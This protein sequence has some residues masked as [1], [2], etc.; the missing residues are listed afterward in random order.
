MPKVS[1]KEAVSTYELQQVHDLNHRVF[2]EEIAQHHIH[3]SGLLIDRFHDSNRYFIAVGDGRVI[4]MISANSGP[5]FSIT[6]RLPNATVLEDFPRPVELRLLAILPEDR[7][8]TVLAGLLWQTYDFAVSGGFSHLLISAIA[9][10]ESM[11]R[12][13]GFSPLGTA[14]PEGAARFIPMVMAINDQAKTHKRRVQLHERRWHRGLGRSELISLMPG[15]VCIHPRVA[16]AFASSPVSHRSPAF[17]DTYEEVRL[18][19]NRLLGGGMEVTIFPGGGTLANDAIAANLKTI[20]GNAEGLVLTNGEFGERLV[21][22]AARADLKF[23]QLQ[24]SWGDAWSFSAIKNALDRKPAWLWAVHLET[25]TGVLNDI[26]TLL[27]L[28]EAARCTV[29][30]DCVS[31]LGASPIANSESPLILASGVSGKSLGSYTGLSFV[32]LSEECRERL[33]NKLLRPSFDLLRMHQTQGPIATVPSSL[34]LA[35]D[36]ALNDNYGSLEAIASRY[37]EYQL[38]GMRTR[39]EMRIASL[40]PLATDSIAAPNITTF[41]LP[42]TFFAKACLEAGYQIAHESPYLQSRGW[43]QIA[44]M[45]NITLPS[46]TSLFASWGRDGSAI[47]SK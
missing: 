36:R 6:K 18:H 45:G 31:S 37:Q 34:V 41:V 32:Y 42:N 13:L 15:P 8:R 5:K 3:R 28:A 23:N 39:H 25:S 33:A 30:L 40:K 17:V 47:R 38:L 46:L 19:L 27:E 35:L 29:A 1:F 2:A 14:V 16:R 43:G 24:F 9:E 22:Q 10:K 21:N 44:T 26:Q 7:N 20:F 12:K 11:Y 4:G